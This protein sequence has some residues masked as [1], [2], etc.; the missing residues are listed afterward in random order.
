VRPLALARE[1]LTLDIIQVWEVLLV[2]Q[3]FH[4]LNLSNAPCSAIPPAD[5]TMGKKG[6]LVD[7]ADEREGS[8]STLRLAW[9]C[10]TF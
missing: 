8:A 5:I 6:T 2:A 3:P 4:D 10:R 1:T 9:Y 7:C